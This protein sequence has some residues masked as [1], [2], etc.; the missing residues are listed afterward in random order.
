[1]AIG[2]LTASSSYLLM[3]TSVQCITEIG[4]QILGALKIKLLLF[5]EGIFELKH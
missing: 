5:F 4:H 1:M 3:N 2:I